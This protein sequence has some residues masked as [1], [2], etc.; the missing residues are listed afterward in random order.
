MKVVNLRDF[1]P[2]L[3]S[4]TVRIDRMTQWGNPF[5]IGETEIWDGF[6]A[7][8]KPNGKVTRTK[9]DRERVIALYGAWLEEQ[10]ELHPD[11]LE[12]L[13]GKDLACWCAPQACHGDVILKW[14]E[15]HPRG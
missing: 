10:M 11:F 2:V 14:L 9:M 1:G 8:G 3:P 12:P 13:R 4:G 5:K 15:E 6:N 7:D